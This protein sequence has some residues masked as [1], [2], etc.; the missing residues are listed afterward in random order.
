[1]RADLAG[2]FD[3]SQRSNS[4]QIEKIPCKFPY[5]REFGVRDR[6]ASDCI[7]HHV[8]FEHR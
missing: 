5:S 7:H 1:L 2:I 4:L 3:A 6:F 8:S